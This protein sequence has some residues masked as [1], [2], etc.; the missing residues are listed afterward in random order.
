MFVDLARRYCEPHRAYHILTHPAEMI[1]VGME[2]G[3]LSNE[4]IAAIWYHDAMYEPGASDNEEKSVMLLYDHYLK[5][6]FGREDLFRFDIVA[7]IIRDTK[8]HIATIEE[9]KR[10]IDLDLRELGSGLLHYWENA[11]R[12]RREFGAFSDEEWK[13]GRIKFLEKMLNRSI[14]YTEPFVYDENAARFNM[15]Y[16]RQLLL[17]GIADYK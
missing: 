8:D 1:A 13:I 6:D 3:G 7:Q 2:L 11:K 15:N 5:M 12:I 4:Q 17:D 9:S 14:F 16:E 10:V